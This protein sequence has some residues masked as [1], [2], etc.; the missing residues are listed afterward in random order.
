[1]TSHATAGSLAETLAEDWI[2]SGRYQ[3][4]DKLPSERQMAEDL[5]VSRPLVREALRGLLE[6][7]LVEIS[8]GRG[9]FVRG[10]SLSDISTTFTTLIRRQQATT[11]DVLVA[12]KMIECEAAEQAALHNN[13]ADLAQMLASLTECED[14][15]GIIERVRADLRFHASVVNAVR[16]PVVSGMYASIATLTAEMMF[17]SLTDTEVSRE[18]LPLHRDIFNAIADGR[19]ADARAATAEHLH[20][21]DR[22]YGE[23]LDRSVDEVARREANRLF[24]ATLDLDQLLSSLPDIH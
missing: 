10:A 4:G 24:G 9:T 5:G 21:A 13:P 22:S 2:L 11:R 3:A 14:A 18:G 16:N 17:R 20:V 8:P 23:D 6:R 19:A 12:R 15:P 7:R 1:M